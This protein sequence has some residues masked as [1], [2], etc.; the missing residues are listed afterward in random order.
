MNSLR[1][2]TL[3]KQIELKNRLLRGIKMIQQ[4]SPYGDL[5]QFDIVAGFTCLFINGVKSCEVPAS[6][7]ICRD[8][9]L[10]MLKGYDE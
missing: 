10:L 7:S 1:M 6:G 5:L 2:E 3:K 4:V 8:I 9:G